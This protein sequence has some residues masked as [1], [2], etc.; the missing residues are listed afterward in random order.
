MAKLGGVDEAGLGP[1]LGPLTLGFSVFEAPAGE[2][3]A[4]CDL[5]STLAPAVTSDPMKD[6]RRF[7]VADSKIVFKRTPRCSKRLEATALGFLALLDGT[8]RPHT[9]AARFL[10]NSP[11]ELAPASDA[12]AMH[13]WYRGHARPLPAHQDASALELRVESLW[14]KMQRSEVKLLDAGVRVLPEGDL[15]RSFQQTSNKAETHWSASV[16]I[17]QRIWRDHAREGIELSIDRHGGRMHYG[18]RLAVA[19]QDAIV[20]LVSEAPERSEYEL[21]ERRGPRAMR[22]IFA[23]RAEQ[24]SFAVAL[25]SC[26]AKYARETAMHAFNQWFAA[27]APELVAT[28]GY[29]NDAQ[30]WLADA[31]PVIARERLDRALLVRD[32]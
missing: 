22:M 5:W 16:A 27:R 11:R 19:F 28:A 25:A 29:R 7:V 17:Y 10:W 8:R 18:S 30:R 1:L 20:T 3:G 23:E 4:A 31:E 26:L 15:N 14:Q 6:K 21:V 24:A 12:V 32:R 2:R 9:D 13:P